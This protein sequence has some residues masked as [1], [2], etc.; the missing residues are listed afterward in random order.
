MKVG[1]SILTNGSRRAYL[2]RC[3]KSLLEN[4]YYRPLVIGIFNNGSTDDTAEWLRHNLPEAHGITWRVYNSDKDR[5]CAWGTNNS[6]KMVDDCE[7]QIHLESDFEHLPLSATGVDKMWLHRAVKHMDKCDYLY[8]RRMR[9]EKEAAM[10]WWDQWMPQITE[11]DGEMLKCQ[12]FWWSNNPS[13][14][15]LEALKDA[16]ILP[17]QENLDGNKGTPAWSQPELQ[18]GRPPN[19]YIHRWGMFVHE[20]EEGEDFSHQGCGSFS[21]HNHTC[22][23]GFWKHNN[24]RW[25]SMC[26]QSKDYKDMVEHRKRVQNG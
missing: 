3:I 17:L 1:I 11:Q 5:G 26:D 6:I 18:A 15:R 14:F 23:Y 4:C 19:A 2:E 13:L 25:C 12:G 10:H 8:L 16:G 21:K 7:L 22:K 24:D 9:D 20:V